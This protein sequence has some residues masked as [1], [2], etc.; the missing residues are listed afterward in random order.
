FLP[1][2]GGVGDF[3]F[4]AAQDHRGGVIVGFKHRRSP[5]CGGWVRHR[6]SQRAAG[7]RPAALS[8]TVKK[9]GVASP[10]TQGDICDASG[11]A[12]SSPPDATSQSRIIASPPTD[13]IRLPSGEIERSNTPP[14]W[15]RNSRTKLRERPERIRIMPS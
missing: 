4:P 15:A 11:C 13:T 12:T 10:S 1:L 3:H 8:A 9:R 5:K 14:S 7:C 2:G 6:E